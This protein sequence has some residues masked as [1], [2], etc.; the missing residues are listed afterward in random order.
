MY[1]DHFKLTD[2]PFLQS[3]K[4]ELYF[5]TPPARKQIVRI[6]HWLD[7]GH[8][9]LLVT[10]I[11]G[12]GRASLVHHAL[13]QAAL[14]THVIT[15][16]GLVLD[17][18]EFLH[19]IALELGL[20]PDRID[21]MTLRHAIKTHLKS[22]ADQASRV[23]LVIRQ[24]ELRPESQLHLLR[25]LARDPDF[26]LPLC[27]VV[28]VAGPAH[29]RDCARLIREQPGGSFHCQIPVAP[30][31][32]AMTRQYLDYR[33]ELVKQ[34]ETTAVE[35]CIP[36]EVSAEIHARSGG[37]VVA[38]VADLGDQPELAELIGTIK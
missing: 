12:C 22:R 27:S 33:W 14:N 36:D 16:G 26:Y 29:A 4:D 8:D 13:A 5:V 30:L 35:Q 18:V 31:T 15:V 6:Q 20:S 17:D 25:D 24:A 32:R 9:F 28:L 10:G 23:C 11:E 3:G 21:S 7:S 1:L 2:F 38:Q 34:Q 37:N 19:Y